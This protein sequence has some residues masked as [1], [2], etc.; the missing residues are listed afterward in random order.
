VGQNVFT[1]R[2]WPLAAR[3]LPAWL[4]VP[5]PED[6]EPLTLGAN[7]RQ[8]HRLQVDLR[9]HVQQV[10]ELDD[11]MADIGV[12]ALQRIFPQAAPLVPDA[13]QALLG[14]LVLTQRRIDRYMQQEGEAAHGVVV[15]TLLA[16]FHTRANAPTVLA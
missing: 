7:P 15:I 3:S 6:I 2:A 8:V 14:P 11:A 4:V 16:V 1:A 12:E 5:G 13:L 9:G 10:A